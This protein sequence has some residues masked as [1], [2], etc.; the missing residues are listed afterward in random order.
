MSVKTAPNMPVLLQQYDYC[1][2]FF[3]GASVHDWLDAVS[4]LTVSDLPSTIAPSIQYGL[5]ISILTTQRT[6]R[7]LIGV[8][9]RQ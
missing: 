9:S 1:R 3:I 6:L 7:G 2:N 4:A 8:L 5:A